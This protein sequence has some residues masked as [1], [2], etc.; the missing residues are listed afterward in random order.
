MDTWLKAVEGGSV[1]SVSRYRER[2]S[3]KCNDQWDRGRCLGVPMLGWSCESRGDLQSN[4]WRGNLGA[5]ICVDRQKN[6]NQHQE[7]SRVAYWD[8]SKAAY[9]KTKKNV[10][11]MRN[12]SAIPG[13]TYVHANMPVK[14][15][16]FYMNWTKLWSGLQ[17]TYIHN[18]FC[19]KYDTA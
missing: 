19:S 2:A 18:H 6:R 13:G 10:V 12:D 11:G 15:K 4:A 1:Q 5:R 16:A 9:I 14:Q 7:T 17:I 3:S 8:L